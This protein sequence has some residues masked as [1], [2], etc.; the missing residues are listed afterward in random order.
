M[1]TNERSNLK[2]KEKKRSLGNL[3]STMPKR[4]QIA[5]DQKSDLKSDPKKRRS[6]LSA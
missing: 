5:T 4:D 2:K 1:L 6:S 3:A